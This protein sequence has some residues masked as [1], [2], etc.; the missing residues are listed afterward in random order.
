M[1]LCFSFLE[2]IVCFCTDIGQDPD[3]LAIG[4]G[5][6]LVEIAGR[7]GKLA[8]RTAKLFF[9]IILRLKNKNIERNI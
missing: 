2:S 9:M 4:H 6:S 8:I 5:V 3:D 1:Y 7:G